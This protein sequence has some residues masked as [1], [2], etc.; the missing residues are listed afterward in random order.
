MIARKKVS[1]VFTPRNP[2]VNIDMY[3]PR[4][5]L[6]KKLFRSVEGSM[7]SF[8]FGE[9]GNGKSWLYKK[10]FVDNKINYVT[11]NCANASRKNSI[12][13][14]IYSVCVSNGKGTKVG[15]SET[16]KTKVTAIVAEG[17]LSHEGQYEILQ[18]DKLIIAFRSLYKKSHGNKSVIVLDNVETIFKSHDLMDELSDIIILLDDERYA[19]YNIKFLIVGIPNEVMQYFSASKNPTSVGNRIEEIQRVSGLDFPQVRDLVRHG[20]TAQL[21]IEIP[22]NMMKVLTRHIFE[23]TLGVPQ[24]VHEYCECLGH[25]IEDN[26]WVYDENMIDLSDHRWLSKGLRECYSVISSFLNSEETSDGRRN[27]VMFSLGTNTSHDIDTFEVGKIL[28]QE[29]PDTAPASN[30]GIGNVLSYLSKGDSPILKYIK[31][32]NSYIFTDPRYLM[33]IRVILYK[34]PNTEKVVKK[35]FKVN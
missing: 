4:K 21:K 31:N 24:R 8:L 11:A 26:N 29:F 19:Q 12:L 7:H 22:S 23:I 14:E 28:K 32:S 25:C 20:L 18:E 16:K 1:E 34:V 3:I 27:Q 10:V 15:Y 6:E 5:S 2:V 33:C 17:E 35:S 30:S 13:E 9:S